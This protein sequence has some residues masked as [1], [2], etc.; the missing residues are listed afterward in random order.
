VLPCV[1]QEYL[2]QQQASGAAT[3]AATAPPSGEVPAHL[4]ALF[5]QMQT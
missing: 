3:P 4:Q 1:A 2:K 5:K